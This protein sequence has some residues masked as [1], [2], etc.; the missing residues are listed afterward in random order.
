M[1]QTQIAQHTDLMAQDKAAADI[2][3]IERK[4]AAEKASIS[5]ERVMCASELCDVVL[6]SHEASISLTLKVLQSVE[7]QVQMTKLQEALQGIE[8]RVINT[9]A[10]RD[11]LKARFQAETERAAALKR[12]AL[13]VTGDLTEEINKKFEQWPITIEELE[14]DISRLQEQADAIL[15][16]NPA[17]LDEF[18]KR[19]AEMATLTKTLASEK[20]ELAVEHAAITSVK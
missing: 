12:D 9:K 11:D 5:K 16:H 17:V 2:A 10:K 19:K 20:A 1:I 4:T 15:C 7:K 6:S 13:A 3:N 14:F 8:D 18:N